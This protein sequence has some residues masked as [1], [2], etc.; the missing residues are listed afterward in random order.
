M[1]RPKRCVQVCASER[2]HESGRFTAQG[3]SFTG[4]RVL[5]AAG[6]GLVDRRSAVG[7]VVRGCGVAVPVAIGETKLT[8]GDRTR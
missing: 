1:T 2:A 6:A 4:P 8:V 5:V 3:Y 7:P